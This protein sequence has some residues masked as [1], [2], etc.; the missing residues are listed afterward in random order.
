MSENHIARFDNVS[1]EY[2]ADLDNNL[3]LTGGDS[4]FFYKSKLEHILSVIRQKP[5]CV[6]DFGCATGEFT[7]MLTTIFPDAQITGYDPAAE[8]IKVANQNSSCGNV[9]FIDTL[10]NLPYRPDFIVATGVF[11]H[12]PPQDKQRALSDLFEVMADFGMIIVFE[13]NLFSPF[14][15]L[16]V[17]MAAVDKGATLIKCSS[18]RD[19]LKNAGFKNIRHKYISFFPPFLKALLPIE[20]LLE[21]CPAGAQ[22]LAVAEKTANYESM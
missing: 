1:K 10:Q 21:S 3:R 5:S 22:Y 19:M 7:R 13:H 4:H 20:R 16:I 18:M 9:R 11:H 12:I 14:T 17:S 6:L 15:Q 2:L 8:C